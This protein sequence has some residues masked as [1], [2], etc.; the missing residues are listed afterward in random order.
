MENAKA[1]LDFA[2]ALRLSGVVFFV[3]LSLLTFL[4]S[5]RVQGAPIVQ[6]G[7]LFS[8]VFLGTGIL[9]GRPDFEVLGWVVL[10]TELLLVVSLIGL[11]P[12]S[13]VLTALGVVCLA[14]FDHSVAIMYARGGM[15]DVSHEA[16]RKRLLSKRLA[17][18]GVTALISLTV[19]I[20]GVSLAPPLMLSGNPS[21]A[22][23]VL[24]V[25]VVLLIAF[26]TSVYGGGGRLEGPGS[27]PKTRAA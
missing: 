5:G 25:A 22:V 24:A 9:A 12:L 23:G 20:L 11:G 10:G 19:S 13:A 26:V 18:I 2:A 27:Y 15:I 16:A 21:L 8:F 1:R 6:L 3:T 17:T 7:I 4:L 14:D